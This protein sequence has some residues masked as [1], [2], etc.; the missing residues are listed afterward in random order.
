MNEVNALTSLV[1]SPIGKV[2]GQI[3]YNSLIVKVE[4]K[5]S[6]MA[7]VMVKAAAE[8]SLVA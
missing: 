2:T 6:L 8:I 4:A 1:T 7:Y 5:V 3:K